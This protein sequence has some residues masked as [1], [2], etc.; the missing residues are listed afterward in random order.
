MK[1][2]Y[3]NLWNAIS[4]FEKSRIICKISINNPS[5]ESNRRVSYHF[6]PKDRF[7][8]ISPRFAIFKIDAHQNWIKRY[9]CMHVCMYVN[10]YLR[11]QNFQRFFENDFHYKNCVDAYFA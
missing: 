6:L 4:I 2:V 11:S 8:C 10:G 5:V 7:C 9:I 1:I 3:K